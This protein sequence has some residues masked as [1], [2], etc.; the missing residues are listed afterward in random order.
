MTEPT[1]LDY[2]K[3]IFKDWKSFTAFVRAWADRA[4]TTQLVETSAP[5]PPTANHQ[6]PTVDHQ[7]PTA[8]DQSPTSFPW[9]SLLAVSLA[10]IAQRSFEPPTQSAMLGAPLYLAAFA[11]ALWAFARGEWTP[12]TLPPAEVKKDPLSVRGFTFILAILFSAAAFVAMSGNTFTASNL[13]IWLVAIVLHVRAFWLKEP[14]SAW[15][16]FADGLANFKWDRRAALIGALVL[17]IAASTL[18][19]RLYRLESVPPE[20]TS[21][22]AE[23]LMDVFDITQGKYSIFFPRNTGREPLYIYLSAWIAGFTGI[24]FLTI[25]IAAVIG[26]LLMLPYLYLLGKE[27]GSARIGLLAVAFAGIAYWPSVIERFALRISFYPLFV[28]PTLYYLIRGLRRQNRNDFIL[29]GLFLGL[30]LG[31]YTPFRIMP[32]AVVA[33]VIVYLLHV[34]DKQTRL[35]TSLWLIL[36]ALTSFVIFIPLASYAAENPDM[37]AFRA[38]SRLGSVERPLPGPAWELFLGNVWNALKEFN[39]NDGVIWVHSIPER[40]ALDVVSGAFFLLGVLLLL[41]RYLRSRHWADLVLLLAIPLTQLPSILSL[42]FPA[43]NP[44][45][46]R[47]AGAIVPVFLVVAVALDGL[48]SA[49]GSEKKRAAL[50]WALVGIL[51]VL[52]F[53][54]NYKLVFHQYNDQYRASAWNTSEMGGVMKQFIATGK[55]ADNVWIVPYAF[56][57]DTRL[58]PFWAG[59]PGRDIAIFREKLPATTLV[60][61]PKLFMVALQDTDTLAVLQAL[62]PGGALTHYISLVD[63]NHDFWI[64]EVP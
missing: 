36:L 16:K 31:G 15:K 18:F 50:G 9:R 43:E 17:T 57:V 56:W 5:Q 13:T 46:N 34:R 1:V 48:V 58:P 44:S 42:A 26:G 33:I 29:A 64:F 52:S 51:F 20:M 59:E 32:L 27:M 60:S 11:L 19:F 10:L 53:Q 22:H 47:T 12:A 3:S 8:N 4:D 25:K 28:A 39:W 14:Q 2:V 38:L 7:P 24:S 40:P 41:I 37:F 54:Q 55:P 35:Q 45:L 6:P 21:D 61:G 62:Y 63:Q 49:F 30:G 23:K